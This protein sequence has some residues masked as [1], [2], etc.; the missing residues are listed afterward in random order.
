MSKS[1][2][3]EIIKQLKQELKEDV[4]K[5]GNTFLAMV[6]DDKMF[7]TEDV[8]VILERSDNEPE[9]DC[10]VDLV[11]WDNINNRYISPVGEREYKYAQPITMNLIEDYII[12][13][14]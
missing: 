10:Y 8:G 14:E 2:L 13:E 5:S 3:I 12:G 4:T 7:L 1:K 11:R 9:N 6:S